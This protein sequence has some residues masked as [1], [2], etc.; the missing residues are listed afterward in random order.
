MALISFEDDRPEFLFNADELASLMDDFRGGYKHTEAVIET[1]KD[2]KKKDVPGYTYSD[3]VI[4][5][6]D[7]DY[8]RGNKLWQKVADELDIDMSSEVFNTDQ[9]GEMYT[10]AFAQ[11]EEYENPSFKDPVLEFPEYL[12]DHDDNPETPGVVPTLDIAY[13]N[14]YTDAEKAK[15]HAFGG[16]QYKIGESMS[17][18]YEELS[19]SYS[20][21][22]S[23]S[24]NPEDSN[25]NGNTNSLYT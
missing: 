18:N 19:A 3:K 15:K 21:M 20:P 8:Y 11:N 10:F 25:F 6:L 14:K 17:L 1:V 7:Y 5:T 23:S 22:P 24:G 12:I 16:L 4:A 2:K 9:L 13:T